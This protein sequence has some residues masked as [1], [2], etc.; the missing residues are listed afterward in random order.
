MKRSWFSILLVVG[1]LG[2]LGLLA[3]LQSVWLGQISEGEKDRITRRLQT[4][5]ERFGEDFNRE[6]QTA[7][8][9]F[10]SDESLWANKN[11][12]EFNERYDFWRKKTAYPA[13]IKDFYYIENKPDGGV[14]QFD[15][16]K[17]EFKPGVLTAEMQ[18]IRTR[19]ADEKTFEPVDEAHYTLVMAIFEAPKTFD[20]IM[21]RR[22]RP[23]RLEKQ[24][25]S[26]QGVSE[27]K[28]DKIELPERRGFLVIKLDENVI[29]DQLLPDLAKKH[30][31]ENDFNLAVVS[32]TGQS[33]FQTG[34]VTKADSNVA[35][36]DLTPDNLIFFANRDVLPRTPERKAE[37][38]VINQSQIR[39]QTFSTVER[40][41]ISVNNAPEKKQATGTFQFRLKDKQNPTTIF[42]TS[43]LT[44]SGNWTLNVQHSAGSL[45]NFIA[46]TRNKNLAVSF[47]ILGVLAVS[48]VLIFVSAQRARVLAQRQI[49][50]VSSVSHEFRTPL[51]V[52]YSAGE[53][54]ADG[55]AREERQVS[56]YG[57][58]IKSEGK[59]LSSMVEQIL[60][61]AGAN[62]GKKKYDFREQSVKAI[63][64]SA[65]E[66]CA[67]LIDEKGFI[68]ETYFENNLPKVKADT[69]ALSQAIQNLIVNSVKYSK[70]FE[71][72]ISVSVECN[73]AGK[74]EITVED[75]GIGIAPKDLKHIF[76]PFF[77][78]KAVV[79][80]Q[81]HGNGLGLSLVKE[82]V[83][84]HGGKI[85]A[86]SDLGKGSKFSVQ[87]PV[88][89]GRKKTITDHRPPL[90]EP[91]TTDR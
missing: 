77:R 85:R 83:E 91:P 66:E 78:A 19:S 46:G 55:V 16:E 25:A 70:P 30:F 10:Q 8:V 79:D 6:I 2:L 37:G 39:T 35:L 11:W 9:N 58:L 67:G 34:E 59:K 60:E 45:D 27:T 31:P 81:I 3:V 54:L 38:L 68:V 20:R 15:A 21:I 43:N 75:K 65:L 48:I 26:G 18:D 32:R 29:K 40:E 52:I 51:A 33:I 89:G 90:F 64:E 71:K 73:D 82:T 7:Y 56:R 24:P 12:A 80:E 84:A 86:E 87:L 63:V 47:G 49:D 57:D 36:F 42:Q 13:L 17:R 61:F 72:P 88:V 23:P 41:T 28:P 62:S 5:T 1:L 14:W 44:N 50:F 53:N 74:I 22:E 4:D 76:E 69:T